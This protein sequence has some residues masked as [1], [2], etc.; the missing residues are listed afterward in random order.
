[1]LPGERLH[2]PLRR[3]RRRLKPVALGLFAA[4]ALPASAL[5]ANFKIKVHIAT[6]LSG[7]GEQGQTTLP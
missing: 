3:L 1:M 4:L 5:A 6:R 7:T 2:T